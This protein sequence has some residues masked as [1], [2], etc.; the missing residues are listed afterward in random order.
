LW[1][2]DA[3]I[4]TIYQSNID[5]ALSLALVLSL[6]LL[7][8]A[9]VL[10]FHGGFNPLCFFAEKS[11][12]LSEGTTQT[13]E[14]RSRES[15]RIDSEFNPGPICQQANGVLEKYGKK[16]AEPQSFSAQDAALPTPSGGPRASVQSPGGQLRQ[17]LLELERQIELQREQLAQKEEVIQHQH[18][19]LLR[20]SAQIETQARELIAKEE[21]I[22][23]LVMYQR[24]S[25][26]YGIVVLYGNLRRHLPTIIHRFLAA[27][28]ELWLPKLGILYQ[29]PPRTLHLRRQKEVPVKVADTPWISMVTPSLNQGEYIR[30][31][32]D[33]VLE[34]DYPRLQYF[35]Q[36]GGS[37]DGTQKILEQYRSRVTGV[38][39]EPDGGQ[40]DA[41]NR[42]F[43]RASGE[44]MAWL[45]AD[46]MLL[47]GA[48]FSVTRFF[49]TH[50]DVDVVYGN[51]IIIDGQGQEVGRW[52]LPPHDKEVLW[53][54][55][56]IPQETVFWRRRIWDKVGGQVDSSFDFALDWDLLLRFQAAGAKFV[57]L[58]L[59][60]GAFRAHDRQK[61]KQG[62]ASRGYEEMYHLRYRC[63]GRHVTHVEADLRTRRYLRRHLLHHWLH[64]LS[65]LVGIE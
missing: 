14:L 52:V 59:F 25:L 57:R 1:H 38:I 39:S 29:Y 65:R 45:N 56:Y 64:R 27:V 2:G 21:V 5:E 17:K 34:Q 44:I 15:G 42:G 20:Q 6:R 9:P 63:H 37:A 48:L 43:R 7:Q 26:K 50:P 19:D 36:D 11:R 3:E 16:A 13:V 10:I 62:I 41:I 8:E 49:A 61:T 53:W 18:Q 47:P 22:Q 23:S 12:I 35:I 40:A 30:Q 58:P 24:S 4:A 28:G 54:V 33:S 32:I 51:R 31:T 60:L 55:D 46:D